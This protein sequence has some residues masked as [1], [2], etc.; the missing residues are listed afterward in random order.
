MGSKEILIKV[1]WVQFFFILCSSESI[2]FF[3]GAL[4]NH[5]EF[6]RYIFCFSIEDPEPTLSLRVCLFMN[7]GLYFQ[8]HVIK[9]AH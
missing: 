1:V 8:P 7:L 2:F 3:V 6:S 9:Q 4:S 5:H